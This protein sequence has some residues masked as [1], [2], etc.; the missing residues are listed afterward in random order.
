MKLGKSQSALNDS[1]VKTKLYRFK[2]NSEMRD[3]LCA[4]L[5]GLVKVITDE[6]SSKIVGVQIMGN[7][8]GDLIS[9]AVLA[10]K[11]GATIAQWGNCPH[12][13]PFYKSFHTMHRLGVTSWED[14]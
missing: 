3:T 9:E 8:A 6:Q 13:H 4:D 5:K 10:L 11:C 12:A 7:T 2:Y 1:G 14:D